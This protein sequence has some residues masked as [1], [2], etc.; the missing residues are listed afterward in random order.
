MGCGRYVAI[1]SHLITQSSWTG[2]SVPC[3]HSLSATRGSHSH[4]FRLWLFPD[5][6]FA[7]HWLSIS[8][9]VFDL[10]WTLACTPIIN[11]IL[12]LIISLLAITGP[13]HLLLHLLHLHHLPPSSK[14]ASVEGWKKGLCH[15]STP[16]SLWSL[17]TVA[18]PP[19]V[20][21][22]KPK[23]ENSKD[24]DQLISVTY[25]VITPLL[26]PA[27]GHSLRSKSRILCRDNCE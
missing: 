16:T 4:W 1:C 6:P 22:F 7:R 20:A 13:C 17:S 8:S 9:L 11:D 10:C 2:G 18:V 15:L 3:W 25:T 26:N 21:C 24:E 23:S 5:C 14:I 19:S 27:V 12:T